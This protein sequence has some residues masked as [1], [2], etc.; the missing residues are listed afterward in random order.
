MVHHERERLQFLAAANLRQRFLEA[1]LRGQ[2]QGVYSVGVRGGGLPLHGASEFIV[3]G[4]PVVVLA[5]PDKTQHGV[6]LWKIPVD[7]EGV[8]RR[9]LG[10]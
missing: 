5:G 7:L 2:R 10:L 4:S 9:R 3:R 6:R 8:V 1:P